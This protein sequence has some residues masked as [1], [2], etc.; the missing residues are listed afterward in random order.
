MLL[1]GFVI[2]MIMIAGCSTVNP[3]SPPRDNGADTITGLW[4]SNGSDSV[5]YFH[6][7]ENGTF[8]AGSDTGDRHPM[9]WFRYYGEWKPIGRAVYV[10]S[11]QHIGYGEVTALAIWR[12][13]TLLYNPATDTFTIPAYEDQMFTRR[14]SIPRET[15]G[16]TTTVLV[17]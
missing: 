12:D 17:G 15:E 5:T 3:G 16:M 10:T 11:G 4:I 2:I 13:L 6:F 8:D 1:A 7:Y 14:E 9:Y